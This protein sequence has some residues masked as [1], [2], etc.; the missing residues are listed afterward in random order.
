MH[1]SLASSA[2]DTGQDRITAN[3]WTELLLYYIPGLYMSFMLLLWKR[4]HKAAVSNSNARVA[5]IGNTIQV[6]ELGIKLQ[7]STEMHAKLLADRPDASPKFAA[8]KRIQRLDGQQAEVGKAQR[9]LVEEIELAIQKRDSL[10]LRVKIL[11]SKKH[12]F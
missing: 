12:Y 7:L 10:L 6:G 3:S 5:N 8:E 1:L 2:N 11:L 4:H 9:K